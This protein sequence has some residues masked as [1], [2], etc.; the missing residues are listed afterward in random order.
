MQS[1][2]TCYARLSSV[3]H[4]HNLLPV[5]RTCNFCSVSLVSQG[6]WRHCL[7]YFLSRVLLASWWGCHIVVACGESFNP[8]VPED[9]LIIVSNLSFN[10]TNHICGHLSQAICF[11]AIVY[12][13]FSKLVRRVAELSMSYCLQMTHDKIFFAKRVH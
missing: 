11:I 5:L 3:S 1:F 9:M 6:L 7:V 2:Q 10:S 12:Y 4:G 8:T 13:L